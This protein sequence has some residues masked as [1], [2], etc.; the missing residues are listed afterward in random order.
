MILEQAFTPRSSYVFHQW[1]PPNSAQIG[2]STIDITI[3]TAITSRIDGPSKIKLKSSYKLGA[4]LSLSDTLTRINE[5][6]DSDLMETTIKGEK[7]GVTQGE[8]GKMTKS[9]LDLRNHNPRVNPSPTRMTTLGNTLEES[10]IPL[11]EA[12][13]MVD[14]LTRHISVTSMPSETFTSTL[15]SMRLRTASY[16]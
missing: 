10:S 8:I 2:P 13:S 3:I 1:L 16:R 12:S 4:L 14:H 9:D 6:L 7:D 5:D 15:S 11:Q